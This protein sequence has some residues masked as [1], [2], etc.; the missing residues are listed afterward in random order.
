MKDT[1]LYEFI[2]IYSLIISTD[3]YRICRIEMNE[4]FTKK[5]SQMIITDVH[6][7]SAQCFN[8]RL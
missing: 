3:K 4:H 7:N 6:Y 1:S 8:C 2:I 5:S